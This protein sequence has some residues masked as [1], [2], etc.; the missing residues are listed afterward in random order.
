LADQ[1]GFIRI[2]SHHILCSADLPGLIQ[3]PYEKT[4][5]A[6]R[7]QSVPLGLA[8]R[9]HGDSVDCVDCVAGDG[10]RERFPAC[11]LLYALRVGVCVAI[12]RIRR[13]FCLIR[14][15]FIAYS[16]RFKREEG[17]FYIDQSHSRCEK[18]TIH[19][20]SAHFCGG[21]GVALVGTG[22]ERCA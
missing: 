8:T 7:A 17:E 4:T 21:F 6:F 5:F 12:W 10:H 22:R 1:V 3:K 18:N 13:G 11:A 19:R 2:E 9:P 14:Q 16:N 15:N 20:S